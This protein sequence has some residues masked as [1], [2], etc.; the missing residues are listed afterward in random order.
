MNANVLLSIHPSSCPVMPIDFGISDSQK[1]PYQSVAYVI[2][3]TSIVLFLLFAPVH[4]YGL[5]LLLSSL[6]LFFFFL[7]SWPFSMCWLIA[8]L[9]PDV[10][11]NCL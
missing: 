7:S 11:L 9:L 10:N 8:V 4:L 6:F 5:I 2:R 1:M 3:F